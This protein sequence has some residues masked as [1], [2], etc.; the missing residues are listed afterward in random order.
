MSN[1]LTEPVTIDLLDVGCS[2]ALD[3]KWSDLFPML[4]YTG[5][6][7]NADE[8]ERLRKQPHPYK[9][10]RYL[11]FA[12]AATRGTHTLYKTKNKY[13][14]S[15]LRPNHPWL[16]RFE[17]GDL[18]AETGTESVECTTLNDLALEH[19]LAADIIK[20]DSQG[21]DLEILRS[22]DRLLDK[23]F[24]VE[25]E[26]G[27]VE[28]YVGENV[29]A[30]V[31]E[32][33]RGRGFLLFDLK[34][35]RVARNNP[36]AKHGRHQPMWCETTWFADVVGREKKITREQAIKFILIARCLGYFDYGYELACYARDTGVF[37]SDE[38]S[39]LRAPAGWRTSRRSWRH[40]SWTA[41]LVNLLPMFLKR[42]LL[43]GLKELLD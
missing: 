38:L 27:F 22:G 35:F 1:P 7:P 8:C 29:Y 32:F 16:A 3:A 19:H 34:V 2:G 12:L 33:L 14:Y 10:C 6:D 23:A 42:R 11:P 15:L 20:V 21:L 9:Q 26:P 41:N 4:S 43:Y 30:Q 17:Y 5:F 40:L 28:N 31:D 39:L 18:F 24:G 13:C 37:T 36:L 25:S